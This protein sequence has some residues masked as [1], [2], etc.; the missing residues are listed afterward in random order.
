MDSTRRASP[1]TRAIIENS[2]NGLLVEQHEP[3]AVARAI[4]QVLG[5]AALR[6]Q[7]REGARSSQQ[8]YAAGT[9]TASYADLFQRITV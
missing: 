5:D 6:D 9:V 7:L 1:G 4:R 3:A 8:A 2:V